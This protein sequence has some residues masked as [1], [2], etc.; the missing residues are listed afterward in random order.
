MREI[1]ENRRKAYVCNLRQ[2]LDRRRRGQGELWTL[3]VEDKLTEIQLA[4][5]RRRLSTMS[6]TAVMDAYRSAYFQCRLEGDKVPPACPVQTLV[7]AWKEM[8]G[9]PRRSEPNH[10]TGGSRSTASPHSLQMNPSMALKPGNVFSDPQCGHH[11][12]QIS[13]DPSSTNLTPTRSIGTV[14]TTAPQ[15]LH[16]RSATSP[17]ST[18]I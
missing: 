6:V 14:S 4:E 8:R 17:C 15:E 3:G 16:L 12:L 11:S 13:S 9:C 1:P 2:R 5:L 7:Q 18:T 10:G